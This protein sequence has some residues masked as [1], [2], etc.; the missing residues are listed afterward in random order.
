MNAAGSATI[1]LF[2]MMSPKQAAI[3]LILPHAYAAF[4]LPDRLAIVISCTS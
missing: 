4:S 1:L 2:R 3:T